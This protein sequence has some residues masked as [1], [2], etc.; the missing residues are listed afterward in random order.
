MA[1]ANPEDSEMIAED[2]KQIQEMIK[3][4]EAGTALVGTDAVPFTVTDITGAKFSLESLKG[5]VVVLNF[6]FI[7]CKPCV[8][9]IPELNEL[10]EKYHNEDVVF[11]GFANDGMKAI[12]KFLT[13]QAFDYN[14]IPNSLM[15]AQSY[16][17]FGFPTHIVINTNSKIELVLSGLSETTI[18]EI[19]GM[20]GSLLN[21]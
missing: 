3:M 10:V 13:K 21:K 8:M 9:E 6:W 20:I 18:G 12:E 2:M 7:A 19:D 1:E 15:T 11:I 16:Q 4:M 17:V 14:L 5:K